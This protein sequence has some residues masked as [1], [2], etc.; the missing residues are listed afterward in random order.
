M[1]ETDTDPMSDRE[2]KAK[3]AEKPAKKKGIQTPNHKRKP[4]KLKPKPQPLP[5]V[6]I[7]TLQYQMLYNHM[8]S[9]YHLSNKKALY[10]NMK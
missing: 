6:S 7:T 3:I 5:E 8:E 2:A 10:Y 1:T 4:D 9:N